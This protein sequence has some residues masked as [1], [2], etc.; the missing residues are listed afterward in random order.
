MCT[1]LDLQFF[2]LRDVSLDR[3][4]TLQQVVQL[5][6]QFVDEVGINEMIIYIHS[7]FVEI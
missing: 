7:H 4:L 5:V 3:A 1:E 6:P 2:E